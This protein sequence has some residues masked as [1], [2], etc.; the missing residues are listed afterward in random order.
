[1]FS[2]LILYLILNKIL[3]KQ[4]LPYLSHEVD[5]SYFHEPHVYQTLYFVIDVAL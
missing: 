4:N 1:M 2:D 3:T 5:Y